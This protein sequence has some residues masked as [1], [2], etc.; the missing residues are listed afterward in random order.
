MDV[1]SKFEAA[2]RAPPNRGPHPFVI[3]DLKH[4]V[5]GGIT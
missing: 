1:S 2:V 3:S 4:L 5:M